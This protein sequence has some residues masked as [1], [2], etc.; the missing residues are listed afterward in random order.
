MRAKGS[1]GVAVTKILVALRRI[2]KDLMHV[3]MPLKSAPCNAVYI[4]M[5]L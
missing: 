3:C 4:E 1:K 2:L 5:K